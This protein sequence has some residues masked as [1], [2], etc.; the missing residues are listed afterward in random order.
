MEIHPLQFVGALV[1]ALTVLAIVQVR[2]DRQ[3][4]LRALIALMTAAALVLGVI[5]VAVKR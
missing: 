5:S 1:A 4:S 3:F 2:K